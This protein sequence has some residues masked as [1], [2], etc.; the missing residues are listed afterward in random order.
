MRIKIVEKN[1]AGE[2]VKEYHYRKSKVPI[3]DTKRLVDIVVNDHGTQAAA[4]Y[5]TGIGARDTIKLLKPVLDRLAAE[6][7]N[8]NTLT[9]DVDYMF[10]ERNVANPG[11][12][13]V[14]R[15]SDRY[16]E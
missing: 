9:A 12:R 14:R 1:V 6:R 2:V 4:F 7:G 13:P 16:E 11:S 5:Q 10:I 15:Y 8:G 3:A